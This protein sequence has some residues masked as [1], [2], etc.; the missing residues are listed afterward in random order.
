MDSDWRRQVAADATIFPEID[1]RKWPNPRS[2]AEEMALHLAIEDAPGYVEMAEDSGDQGHGTLPEHPD[3]YTWEDC[4]ELLFEDHDVLS[5]STRAST[6]SK[7]P[8]ATSR[9]PPA[10]ATCARGPGS[11]ASAT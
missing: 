4:S 9:G 3:D 10:W 11:T 6:A 7:T 8:T 1:F 5:P 2:T